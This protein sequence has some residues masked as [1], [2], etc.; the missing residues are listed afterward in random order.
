ME[1][2]EALLDKTSSRLDKKLPKTKEVRAMARKYY[3]CYFCGGKVAEKRVTVDYRWGEEFIAVFKNVPAGVCQVC[4]EQYYKA[5]IVKEM[6]RLAQ[7]EEEAKEM[8]R[9]P[10]REFALT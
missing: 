1:L 8:I 5:K 4:G 10:V 2:E 9:V 6:E 3:K 7:S